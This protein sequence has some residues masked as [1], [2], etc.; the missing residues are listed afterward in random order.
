[1]DCGDYAVG[2]FRDTFTLECVDGTVTVADM[3]CDATC[4]G[5]QTVDFEFGGVDENL[6]PLPVVEFSYNVLGDRAHGATQT[7]LCND[8]NDT[9]DGVILVT[10]AYMTNVADASTCD[11]IKY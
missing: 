7:L 10:C 1:M 2:K 5:P 4:F 9:Y 11:T 6:D 3:S 8:F